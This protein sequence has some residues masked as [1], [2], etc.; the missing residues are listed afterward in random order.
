MLAVTDDCIGPFCVCVCV[1]REYFYAKTTSNAKTTNQKEDSQK[2]YIDLMCPL[3]CYLPDLNA[4][5]TIT[6]LAVPS[7]VWCIQAWV[8]LHL[9]VL[10]SQVL[11]KIQI[12]RD[13]VA[14]SP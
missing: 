1:S 7:G 5:T 9:M 11:I 4:P 8:K 6:E 3:I 13:Y 2:V 10:I 12:Q 14:L